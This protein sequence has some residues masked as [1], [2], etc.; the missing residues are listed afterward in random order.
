M[1]KMDRPALDFVAA[2]HEC[3]FYN[4][5]LPTL[6]DWHEII[7]SQSVP[8]SGA[9]YLWSADLT[10]SSNTVPIHAAVRFTTDAMMY[11]SYT[12]TGTMATFYGPT[13]ATRFRCIGK[14]SASEGVSPTPVCEG[15]GCFVVQPSTDQSPDHSGRRA[16]I[17][18]D[19]A[20]R[21]ADTRAQAF[22]TCRG[23]GGSLPTLIEFQELVHAGWD[24]G[25]NAYLWLGS[26]AYTGTYWNP[27][28]RWSGTGAKNWYAVAT[29]TITYNAGTAANAYR[30]VWHQ[31]YQADPISCD[32]G[33]APQW[34]GQ[35]FTCVAIEN[36]DAEGQGNTGVWADSYGNDW[37][38]D[39]RTA[40]T[41][42]EAAATC[43]GLGA[44]P[45]HDHRGLPRASRWPEHHLLHQDGVLVDYPAQLSDGVS[46][47]PSRTSDGSMSQSLQTGSLTYR[48]IWPATTTNVFSGKAC[49][50]PE[51]EGGCFANGR[52]VVGPQ[53]PRVCL[54]RDGGSRMPVLRRL[55]QRSE[56]LREQCSRRLAQRRN[57]LQLDRRT[58]DKQT[59]SRWVAG[60]SGPAP[61]REPLHGIGRAVEQPPA[62]MP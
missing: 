59:T 52:V 35:D 9:N 45:A 2:S 3:N 32:A 24:N 44:Q 48:C 61:P 43:E 11:W 29:T 54:W 12:T 40:A 10:T 60:T 56:G 25:T 5:S 41:F 18:A 27:L 50:D 37:D 34:D 21:A 38:R 22:E 30:C 47:P 46:G 33:E 36:G 57:Q 8:E 17:W 58:G 51:K 49:N 62:P 16:P 26:S 7:H 23:L 19:K 28:A 15:G 55:G 6:E 20:D 14:R 31:Q 53:Q 1:D 39:D 42:A 13:T 4:A